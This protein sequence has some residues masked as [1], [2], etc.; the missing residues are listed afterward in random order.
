MLMFQTIGFLTKT[1][2]IRLQ[3][4]AEAL[5]LNCIESNNLKVK[6][7]RDYFQKFPNPTKVTLLFLFFNAFVAAS[8]LST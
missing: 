2:L 7:R 3:G 8:M 6:R 4:R 1:S 5:P